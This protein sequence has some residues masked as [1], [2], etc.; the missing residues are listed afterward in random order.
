MFSKSEYINFILLI[1]KNLIYLI[2]ILL[3]LPLYC[4]KMKLFY[5]L[6]HKFLYVFEKS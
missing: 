6:A 2:I 5:I 1:L 3:L 4:G